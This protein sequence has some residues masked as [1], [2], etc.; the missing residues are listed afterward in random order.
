MS[1]QQGLS[2][3]NG[4]SRALDAISNNVANSTTVGFKQSGALFADMFASSL[5]SSAGGQ[6]GIGTSVNAVAQQF[7]QGNLTATNNP[8]DVAING[9]GFFRLS[10]NG[11]IVYARDGQ[12]SVDKNGYVVNPSGRRLTGYAADANGNIV[13]A[14]PVDLQVNSADLTPLAT[15]NAT[16]ALNLDSRSSAPTVA[17]FSATDTRTFNTSSSVTTFDTLGNPHVLSMYFVKSATPNTWDL[18][19]TLDGGGAAGPTSM[20]FTTTGGL[21]GIGGVAGTSTVAQSFAINTGAVT[22]FDFTLDFATTTQYGSSFGVNSMSQDGYSSGRLSG[23]T[24]GDDGVIMGRYSNGQSRNLGQIV[25]ANFRAPGGLIQLGDNRWAESA[26]SGPPLVGAPNTGSLGVL[27]SGATEDSN[28]DLTAEL[29]A[30]ITQQRS[31]QANAQS[32]K[33]E[34]SLLQTLV[35]LR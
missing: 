34:D 23:L 30:M 7:T 13:P 10:D 15:A 3:L 35:S 6:I 29:V 19:T 4:A 11:D 28:V 33:T 25:L 12:F 20:D 5:S 9:Q 18:Y 31:Y 26:T 16:V 22:T 2:G 32:I 1:F 14:A 17:P 21:S 27:Q 8:L 24:V